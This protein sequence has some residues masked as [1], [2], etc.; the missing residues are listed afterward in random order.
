MLFDGVGL[1]AALG[2]DDGCLRS[3]FDDSLGFGDFE[4]EVER[5]HLTDGDYN[6]GL[7]LGLKAGKLGAYAIMRRRKA[8]H[9][10]L[11]A[12][13]RLN[14]PLNTLLYIGDGN[15]G[16]RNC[17]TGG[18]DDRSSDLTRRADAL[19]PCDRACRK[20]TDRRHQDACQQGRFHI[21]SWFTKN[22]TNFFGVG[23]S[24]RCPP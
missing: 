13:I 3:H 22:F 16:V 11:A 24:T 7:N 21:S 17:G 6:V 12:A 20:E 1:L 19:S 4:M 8:R 10:V 15:L 2:L 5:D 14:R 18:I 9:A 23:P